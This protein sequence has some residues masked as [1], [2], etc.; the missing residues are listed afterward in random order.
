MSSAPDA[1]LGASG[2]GASGDAKPGEI[3]TAELVRYLD[4]YLESEGVADYGP[5]GLQ[6]EGAPVVRRLVTSV[7]ACRELFERARAVGA[8]A[9]LV[10]H[11]LFWR[12][13]PYPLVGLQY[14]RVAELVRGGLAL[15]AYHLPLDR[16]AEVGN[17][18]L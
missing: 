13:T 8:D 2:S 6:V 14:H 11:G 7:S 3:A 15:L 16:H 10:H 17:N 4:A 9:L 1:S 18:A 5:N 12:G